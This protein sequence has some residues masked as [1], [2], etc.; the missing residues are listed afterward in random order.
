MAGPLLLCKPCRYPSEEPAELR[1]AASLDWRI[2]VNGLVCGI[3]G[4]RRS[5][6]AHQ[7]YLFLDEFKNMGT[8]ETN[9]NRQNGSFSRIAETARVQG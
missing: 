2:A 4:W 5:V 9:C 3:S 8:E 1:G 6:L 7:P